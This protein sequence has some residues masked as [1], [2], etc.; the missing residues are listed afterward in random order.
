M[1]AKTTD[2]SP[3]YHDATLRL[4]GPKE[5]M[6]LWVKPP[7]KPGLNSLAWEQN[8]KMKDRT[9]LQIQR[10]S[11]AAMDERSGVLE[12]REQIHLDNPQ[13]VL[14][15][16]SCAYDLDR[17]ARE[18]RAAFPEPIIGCTTAGQLDG[19]GFAKGGI[20]A[21]ALAGDI[22]AHPYSISLDSMES[23]VD[24][25]ASAYAEAKAEHPLW[26]GFGLLLVD[27]LALMEER[28]ISE[29]Y[30]KLPQLPIVGGS[31]GDD[32]KFQRTHVFARGEFRSRTAVFTL[33][34]T[35]AP[36]T[37][38]KF[39][40]FKPSGGMLV[41]TESD[42]DR[43]VIREING[44]PA[45]EAYATMA[46]TTVAQL[47]ARVFSRHPFVLELGGER[48]IRSI[49]Q[50]NPDKS[51]T[52]YCAIEDGVVLRL[53]QAVD[54][55][56]VAK[57]A[58]QHVRDTVGELALVIGCDCILRRLEFESDGRLGEMAQIMMDNKVFGFSTY[59]EQF[60]GIH[61]NQTFTGIAIGRSP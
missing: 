53:G 6:R 48:F 61:V 39:E 40:H 16:C 15:F 19:S 26:R 36:F 47:N 21:V 23:D 32:L 52:L 7:S 56:E 34:Q 42:P 20:T 50:A 14:F 27:G 13:V 2:N 38:F 51:L 58:F 55:V 4:A 5:R 10:G 3:M 54:P 57:G 60:N 30:Q 43:R 59:G 24:R 37:T 12:L 8:R 44:E 49:Q 46:G 9:K 28:L 17:L 25:I 1:E 35:T 41:I 29:I 22:S 33:F 31:A 18:L 11:S 45:A